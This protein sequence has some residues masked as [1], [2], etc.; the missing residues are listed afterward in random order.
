MVNEFDT[1]LVNSV[2]VTVDVNTVTISP[3]VGLIDVEFVKALANF[4]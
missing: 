1:A 3:I 4:N 2:N